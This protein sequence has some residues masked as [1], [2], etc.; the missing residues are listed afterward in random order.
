MVECLH[1]LLFLPLLFGL[2]QL[3][4]A[5]KLL[6]IEAN[7]GLFALESGVFL[8]GEGDVG[9]EITLDDYCVALPL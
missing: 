8:I 6:L 5:D 3:F 2:V 1:A 9:V 7:H 4:P